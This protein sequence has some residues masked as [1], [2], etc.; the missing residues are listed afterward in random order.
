MLAMVP[1]EEKRHPSLTVPLAA[2]A[3][4]MIAGAPT[5]VANAA[6]VSPVA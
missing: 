2:W 5:G 4:R 6:A 3:E 1:D